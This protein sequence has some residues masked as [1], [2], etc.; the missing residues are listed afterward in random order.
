MLQMSQFSRIDRGVA[1]KGKRQNML[2]MS[3][4]ARIGRGVTLKGKRQNILLM[5]QFI[6]AE[7][8]NSVQKAS[9]SSLLAKFHD[10]VSLKKQKNYAF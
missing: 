5:S 9:E 3:Q 10:G 6:T 4:F 2:Q 1:L 8:R 7:A